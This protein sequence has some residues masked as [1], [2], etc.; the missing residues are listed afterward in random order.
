MSQDNFHAACALIDGS[1]EK[2][3]S[4]LKKEIKESNQEITSEPYELASAAYKDILALDKASYKQ[5][6]EDDGADRGT[7][8]AEMKKY[9]PSSDAIITVI[10]S[11]VMPEG[12]LSQIAEKAGQKPEEFIESIKGGNQLA[13]EHFDENMS[14]IKAPQDKVTAQEICDH[15]APDNGLQGVEKPTKETQVGG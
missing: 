3:F 15:A 4:K 6:L 9:A 1:E 14:K 13:I 8:R 10:E 11:G 5:G 2:A 12:L 7:V